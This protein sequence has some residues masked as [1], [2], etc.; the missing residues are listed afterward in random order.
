MCQRV[1]EP[2]AGGLAGKASNVTRAWPN[3]STAPDCL[4]RSLLRRV[5]FRQRVSASVRLRYETGLR[6]QRRTVNTQQPYEDLGF[7]L[8]RDRRWSIAYSEEL[9]SSKISATLQSTDR[10]HGIVGQERCHFQRDS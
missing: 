6:E 9:V 7:H 4:Q 2:Q 3:A 10:H 1:W 5:R 8:R